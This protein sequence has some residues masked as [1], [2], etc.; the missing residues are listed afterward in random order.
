MTNNPLK[1]Y[2]RTAE[3]YTTLPS[4]THYYTDAVV[5]FNDDGEVGVSPMTAKDEVVLKNP[6]ALLNG[7]AISQVIKSCVP[8]V[9]KPNE[10]LAVDVE[11]LMVAIRHASYG[12]EIE[13]DA[14]CPKCKHS[15]HFA[16]GVEQ[17]LSSMK[18]LDSEYKI[19]TKGGLTIYIRPST[20][21][22]VIKG[23]KAQFENYKIAKVLK[24]DTLPESERITAYS[25]AFTKL[26]EINA[27][28]VCDSIVKVVI[29]ETKDEVTEREHLIEFI[30][31]MDQ[32]VF[33]TISDNLSDINSC[34]VQKEFDATCEKCGHKW[35]TEID[36]NP[37]NFFTDS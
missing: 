15:N 28:L 1:Q 27:E 32:K 4:G 20:Y 24:D 7:Q 6:D 30:Q 25:T 34:G 14:D 12:D 10:L 2:F 37:V 3:L 11:A 23:Y 36:L 26:S 5:S 35:K 17:T 18:K 31:E 8:D 22:E 33:K 19:V 21:H 9:K 16:L 29:N 13:L